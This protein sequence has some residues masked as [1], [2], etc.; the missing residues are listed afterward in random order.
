LF[1]P[2]TKARILAVRSPTEVKGAIIG[3]SYAPTMHS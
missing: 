3:I 1:Q 2:V